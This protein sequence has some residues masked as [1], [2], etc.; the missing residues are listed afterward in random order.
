LV[1][2]KLIKMASHTRL[3]KTQPPPIMDGIV[4]MAI[5]GFRAWC[6]NEPMV[7][8]VRGSS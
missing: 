4:L 7:I 5:N 2:V 8:Y 6:N 3:E 1:V